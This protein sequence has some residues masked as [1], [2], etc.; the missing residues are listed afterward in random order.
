MRHF[1]VD[2]IF[3]SSSYTTAVSG[4]RKSQ[5]TGGG[6][7]GNREE[8]RDSA[9]NVQSQTV[10]AKAKKGGGRGIAGKAK[11]EMNRA[12]T[13]A[14]DTVEMDDEDWGVDEDM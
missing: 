11:D 12:T 6:S 13:V 7:G 4:K 3:S 5:V 2:M 10:E 1:T 14:P 8:G 9:F